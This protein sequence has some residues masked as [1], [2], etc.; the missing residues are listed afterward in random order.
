VGIEAVRAHPG[1]YA[2]GVLATVWD[3]LRRP[4]YRRLGPGAEG[5][6]SEGPAAAAA[7]TIVVGGRRLPRPSEG[8]LIPAPHE[9]GPTTPDGS[10]STVWRSPT[11][12][13]LVFVRERDEE[14]YDAL[15]RRIE[16]LWADLPGRG[17]S[18]TL[19]HRLN[20]ASRLFP[21]PAI[22]LALGVVGLAARR[23]AR[24]LALVTPALAALVV[25]VVNALAIAGVP[26]YAVPAAPAFVLLAAGALFGP[27]R[28]RGARSGAR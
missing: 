4:V 22:W 24:A 25:I 17:G 6:S 27:R 19:A 9:G 8:E 20:Q 11:E 23:P 5:T 2:R 7:D 15:R 1:T 12:H 21:P 16:E 18:R 14:R 26:H 28:V 13:H 3:Q 10:I